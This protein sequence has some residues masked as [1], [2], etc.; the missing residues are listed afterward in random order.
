MRSTANAH[1]NAVD[2]AEQFRSAICAAGL[3]P[4]EL[5]EP[6]KLHRFPRYGQA[7]GNTAGWYTF[8]R[9]HGRLFR[10]LV[11]GFYRKLAGGTRQPFTATERAAFNRHVAEAMSTGRGRAQRQAGRGRDHGGGDLGGG[12]DRTR[13]P[14][15]LRAKASRRT[16]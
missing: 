1:L 16:G 15:Y 10:R 11:C 6:G 9:W 8:R 3:E 12:S 4:P 14:S 13:R 2:S 5:L 7:N